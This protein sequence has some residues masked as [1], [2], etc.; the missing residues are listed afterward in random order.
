MDNIGFKKRISAYLID[1]LVFL[2]FHLIVMVVFAFILAVIGQKEYTLQHVKLKTI[3]DNIF[4]F[5]YYGHLFKRQGQTFGEKIMKI[6]VLPKKGKK[7]N[8]LSAA[9]R[10]AFCAPILA[11]AG[12]IPLRQKD[13]S[14]KSLLEMA[15]F[16]RIVP[17]DESK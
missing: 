9:V 12:A 4:I 2:I 8:L 6:K 13:G 10:Y 7:I 16:T 1:V 11:I 17:A 15:T 14:K 3:V 5:F